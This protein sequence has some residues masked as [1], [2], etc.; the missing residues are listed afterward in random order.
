MVKEALLKYYICN[1]EIIPTSKDY[2]FK[3]TKSP[4]IYEVIRIIEGV[5][6][7]LEEHIER[8]RKSAEIIGKYIKR[9]DDE[10]TDDIHKLID[11]NKEYNMNIKLLC[12]NIDSQN[13]IFIIYYIKSN[14]PER[15][16]YEKGI[17]T[18]LYYQERENPNAKIVNS[19][20][21][22]KVNAELKK[23]NAYEA[24]LVNKNGHITEGSRS[25]IF[26]VKGDK[27]YTAPAGDVLLGIT[28]SKIMNICKEENIEVIEKEN[29]KDSLIDLDGAF[30]T[31]TS[32]NVLPISSI[33]QLKLNSVN[34][35]IIKRIAEGYLKEMK[36]YIM[37][38]KGN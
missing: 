19:D 13:Q 37:E 4:L 31:G 1:G 15:E 6:I 20:L 23:Q 12:T 22:Q 38:R 3:E 10:I 30:M 34:N 9:T 29:H 5:P 25:N 32:V 2:G 36:N 35:I 28:R 21:R 24:L 33:G 16:I 8:L 14:Y 27:V 7:F 17:H 18:I 11:A 26:F